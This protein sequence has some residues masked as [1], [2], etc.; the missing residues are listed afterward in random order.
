MCSCS[1]YVS[2][3]GYG[4]CKKEYNGKPLCYVNTPSTC[5][6]LKNS[7]I[8]NQ[9]FSY[10][11]CDKCDTKEFYFCQE[12][13]RCIEKHI[14]CNK[15]C[16]G[17]MHYSEENNECMGNCSCS[18]YLN[19]DGFGKC[20]KEDENGISLCYVNFPSSCGDLQESSTSLG[21]FISRE[22]CNKYDTLFT[23]IFNFS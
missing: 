10:E 20:L 11:A 7:S 16:N 15:S 17:K 3:S 21:K 9:Y 6:D 23:S 22:A 12:D 4:K 14:P 19:K 2:T 13:N 8:P 1:T 18:L 5:P